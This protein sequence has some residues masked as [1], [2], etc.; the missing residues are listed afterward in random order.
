MSNIKAIL[1]PE[2]TID[3]FNRALAKESLKLV[4]S[5][6]EN[7][8][9]DSVILRRFSANFVG[10]YIEH[11][12][13]DALHDYPKDGTKNEQMKAVYANFKDVKAELEQQVANA[14]VRAMEG[15]SKMDIDYYCQIKAE[16]APVTKSVH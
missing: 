10:Q 13:M 7:A 8:S 2:E 16:P 12:V 5:F 15:Y 3:A 1:T 6:C 11:L 9:K 4:K 14:F